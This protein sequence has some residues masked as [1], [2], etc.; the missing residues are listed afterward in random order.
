MRRVADAE[1]DAILARLLGLHP[2]LIEL[3]LGR[4]ER[5]L[6]ALGHPE[7]A[8]PP[9]IHVAGTNGK[10]STI[11][12][13]RAILEAAGRRVHVYTSPHLVRFAERIRLAGTL[14]SDARLSEALA[15]CE[16]ANA[17]A[18]I[19]FFE[20]TTAAAFH[21]FRN[22]PADVLLLETGLGGRLDA[23]NVVPKPIATV[24]TPISIDHVEFLGPT[25][26]AI[27]GE[28]AGILKRHVPAIIGRQTDEALDVLTRAAARLRAPTQIAGQEF[29]SRTESGR[30]IYEDERGLVDLP[31]PRLA[32]SHQLDNAALA[33]ATLRALDADLQPSVL[34]AGV[35]AAR[36]PARLQHLTRGPLV[37]MA[38]PSSEIWL[39]GGH[40]AD[41][42][43]A[44][45]QAIADFEDAQPRPLVL[46]C[47]M[48]ASKD[49]SGFLRPFKGLAQELLAVPLP[50]DHAGRTPFDVVSTA[51]GEGLA[52]A[53]A[54]GV[55]AAL[56]FLRA[57][58]WSTPPRI[59][60]AG[61]LYLAGDVLLRNGTPPS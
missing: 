44:L 28:K 18:P 52:A 51:Q 37:D 15:A 16:A 29:T 19:T 45:A 36:W 22:D 26:A 46:V 14:V 39:D 31:R 5:L 47:G 48:L 58:T 9:T 30:F 23:T 33:I 12:F 6:A 61:S 27:A 13:L 35:L 7:L 40:N 3:S 25:I 11:A 8:L 53:A 20:I 38:P 54:T 43:R 32:G 17:G 55:E 4:I 34:E 57:R 49:A 21:L 50:G 10:G 59:L 24:I 41:G 1:P 56:A 60:I 2:K 42:G